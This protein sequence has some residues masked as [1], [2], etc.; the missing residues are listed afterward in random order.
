MKKLAV[1]SAVL[2]A[3][4]TSAAFASV[5][6]DAYNDYNFDSR[7]NK[8]GVELGY[9]PIEN[10]DLTAEVTTD[11][12]LDLGVAYKFDI[13]EN[14]YVKPSLG[15]VAKWGDDDDFKMTWG[16]VEPIYKKF[17]TVELSGTNSNVIKLGLE[18]GASFGDLFTS[19]RYRVEIDADHENFALTGPNN[20]RFDAYK[21]RSS[22]G[23]TDLM[24]GYNIANTVTV[25]A[26]GIHRSQLN[27]NIRDGINSVN[28]IAGVFKEK[29]GL[30]NSFWT[31]EVKA[32][33]TSI[34]GVLPYVQYARNY[35]T[36]DDMVK[37]GA[38]FVF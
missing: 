30:V 27:T 37:V 13:A 18:A 32:T 29:S 20:A 10:L 12:D 28:D 24:V 1:A 33:L 35:E 5:S 36:R 4:T 15:Y 22:I 34:D 14:Y 16:K 7:K 11:K 3:L 8:Q 2:A 23:R 9:S 31:S 26:K 38:K 21:E 19:A 17:N 6:V 25:T